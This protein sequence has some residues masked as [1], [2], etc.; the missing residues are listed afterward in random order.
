MGGREA[1]FCRLNSPPFLFLP[2]PPP[3]FL[4]VTRW[5]VFHG[6]LNTP[7][8]EREHTPTTSPSPPLF[9]SSPVVCQSKDKKNKKSVPFPPTWMKERTNVRVLS[10][11]TQMEGGWDGGNN[12]KKT[13]PKRRKKHRPSPSPAKA[14][15]GRLH[16]P[17]RHRV[18]RLQPLDDGCPLHCFGHLL[19]QAVGIE[20]RAGFL[21]VFD[22]VRANSASAAASSTFNPFLSNNAST[23]L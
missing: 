2:P 11:V 7:L 18:D 5:C 6:L 13:L 20:F 17:H 10:R 12:Q 3:P 19:F 22:R 14:P 23:A 8:E 4:C 21:K 9:F 15:L 1:K 16:R